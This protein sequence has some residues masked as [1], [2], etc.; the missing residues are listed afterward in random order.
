[1]NQHPLPEYLY[2]VV[3]HEQ[4]LMSLYRQKIVLSSMDEDFIHLATE[5]QVAHV[6]QKFW[7]N[8]DYLVLKLATKKLIGRLLYETNP[9]G[10]IL[11]YHLYDGS[12]PIDAVVP[13]SSE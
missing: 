12:I 2:K 3:S 1:M 10:S 4:W 6:V 13:C 7:D 5:D 9:G 8:K 11:Y